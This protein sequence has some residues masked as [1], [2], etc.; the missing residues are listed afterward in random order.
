MGEGLKRINVLQVMEATAGGTKRHLYSLV[1]A[2]DKDKFRNV[3]AC[4]SV[5]HPA[6]GDE[7]LVSDL[8]RAG[9]EVKIVEMK[10]SISPISDL[11]CLWRLFLLMKG[12]HYDIVHTHSSKA[13]FLG[14]IAAKMAGTKVIL[15]TPHGLYFLGQRGLRKRFY[16]SLER[17]A[18]LFTDKLIAVSQSERAEV[19][20][21]KIIDADKV[22]VIENGINLRTFDFETN[23]D[24]KQELGLDPNAPI[25]GTVSRFSMQKDPE[26]LIMAIAQVVQAAPET[27]FVWCGNGELREGIE[28]LTTKLGLHE[29]II[30][31]GFREDVL[32]IVAQFDIC[33]ISS[34]FEGLPYTILEA[35]ALRKPVVATDVT[36]SRDVIIDGRTG[37]LVPPQDPDALAQAILCLIRDREMAREMGNAGRKLV[38]E[39][40]GLDQMV[41][42][43]EQL[44]EN[45]LKERLI[46]DRERFGFSR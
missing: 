16:L 5:R 38:E 37:L 44:Y 17:F 25:V 32:K 1:T 20:N 31:T 27:Q 4:P 21:N 6:F 2:M 19:I 39:R 29:H 18:G 11:A 12:D 14:R 41:I 42:K 10:R 24:T 13:G 23:P 40:F 35:M 3:V 26:N 45:L 7:S 36:G 33:V 9:I 46:R 43:T 28:S 34:L 8:E 15:Y 22:T 30:F